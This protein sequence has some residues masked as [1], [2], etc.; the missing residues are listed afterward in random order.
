MTSVNLPEVTAKT[1]NYTITGSENG[2]VLTNRGAG[3]AVTFTLPDPTASFIGFTVRFF[4]VADQNV[5]VR[6]VS[7]SKLT[8]FNNAAA[9]S[10]AFTTAGNL[11][12]SGCT[13][14]CD[15][16]TWLIFLNPG[17]TSGAQTAVQ[18]TIA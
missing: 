18:L 14:V 5:T 15:G 11:I 13:A 7:A 6:A 12:G 3:G 16:T 1:A 9:T 4:N 17:T 10:I 8:V 2:A